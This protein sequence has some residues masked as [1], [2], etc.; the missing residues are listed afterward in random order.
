MGCSALYHLMYVKSES[1][2]TW[3]SR[4]D[5]GGISILIFGSAFPVL[6]YSMACE[7]VFRKWPMISFPTRLNFPLVCNSSL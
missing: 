5:Y 4:L 1:V 6:Y 7:Q 3:L 2:G